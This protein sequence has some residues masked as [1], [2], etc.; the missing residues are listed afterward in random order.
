VSESLV[1]V[2]ESNTVEAVEPLSDFALDLLMPSSS[3]P[4]KEGGIPVLADDVTPGSLDLL[5]RSHVVDY[6]AT[7]ALRESQSARLAGAMINQY[8]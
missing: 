5:C 4:A 1:F 8:V 7:E 2:P 3:I 6:E